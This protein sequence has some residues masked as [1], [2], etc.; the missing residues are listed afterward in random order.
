MLREMEQNHLAMPSPPINDGGIYG[1]RYEHILS[2]PRGII[3]K[4]INKKISQPS[5]EKEVETH[6]EKKGSI[7]VLRLLTHTQ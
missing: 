7:C 5:K 2:L 4:G 1:E 3:S 6:K